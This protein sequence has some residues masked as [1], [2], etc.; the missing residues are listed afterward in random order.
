MVGTADSVIIIRE[1]SFIWSVPY[2]VVPLHTQALHMSDSPPL[3]ILLVPLSVH[4]HWSSA[5]CGGTYGAG[6]GG[7]L[8]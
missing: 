8:W 6:E 7:S 3:P 4:R 5:L 1:V 2:R